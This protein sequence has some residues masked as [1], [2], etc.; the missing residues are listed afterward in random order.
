MKYLRLVHKTWDYFWRVVIIL[1]A[2]T[3]ILCGLLFGV[4]QLKSTKDFLASQAENTYSDQFNGI[5]SIGSF[6]GL[7]PY[8]FNLQDIKVYADSSSAE[9]YIYL[10]SLTF[11]IDPF[12]LLQRE[13]VVNNLNLTNPVI[14]LEYFESLNLENRELN[15]EQGDSTSKKAIEFIV[16]AL[17]I[18]N[19]LIQI[20]SV[21]YADS[22]ISLPDILVLENLDAQLYLDLNSTEQFL[23]IE[24]L[25]F[26]LRNS[27][28]GNI[29]MNGQIFSDA[30]FLEF[31][32]FKLSLEKSF[33]DFSFELGG[34]N[35][36][37][38][39]FYEMIEEAS[40]N[41]DIDASY[42]EMDEIAKVYRVEN[43]P[44]SSIQVEF[45]GLGDIDSL[46]IERLNVVSDD[47]IV[48]VNGYI[49][50]LNSE[51]NLN[52][53][54]NI[55]QA[56]I[57]GNQL[58]FLNLNLTEEQKNSITDIQ[59]S[60]SFGGSLNEIFGNLL[61]RSSRGQLGLTLNTE[62]DND[63]FLN[64]DLEFDSLNISGLFP[65]QLDSTSINGSAS[66]SI[67]SKDLSK[68]SGLAT[69]KFSDVLVDDY[70]IDEI[71][72]ESE[73]KSGYFNPRLIARMGDSGLQLSSEINT[74]TDLN[75]YKL[76]IGIE[77]LNLAEFITVRGLEKTESN[78]TIDVTAY[79]N[80]VSDLY[81]Q[82]SIDADS[83][84][85]NGDTL[86]I[87]QLYFDL[88]SPEEDRV[89]RLTSTPVDITLRGDI[90]PV[91]I[92]QMM[93]HW[94]EYFI[95]RYK[96]ELLF[97]ENI[98]ISEDSLNA[99]QL[100]I[101]YQIQ[102]KDLNLINEYMPAFP[103]I[104]S[105][106]SL[107]GNLNVD[108]KNLLFN[109][110]LVDVFNTFDEVLV[111]SLVT[112]VTGN[113]RYNS[114]LKDFSGLDFNTY[115]KNIEYGE[116]QA[117]GLNFELQLDND[118]LFIFQSVDSLGIEANLY[119]EAQAKLIDS[120]HVLQLNDFQLG[121]DSYKWLNLN[122][123]QISYT[124]N[125][126]LI[127]DELQFINDQQLLRL[128]G[129]ISSDVQDSMFYYIENIELEDLSAIL[130]GRVQFAGLLN[131]NFSTRSL[132][133]SPSIQGDINIDGFEIDE[134]VVGDIDISSVFNEPL[135]RFDT[136]INILTDSLKY[137]DYFIRND[138]SGQNI[139]IAGYI[140]AP[141][142]ITQEIPDSLYNFRL[143]FDDI[144]MWIFPIIAPKVFTEMEGRVTGSGYFKGNINDFDYRI[145][146]SATE[147]I[148]IRP[149]FL[150][151]YY[152]ALG[153]ITF[154]SENGLEFDD[155][156]IIDP[157]GGVGTLNGT[158]NFNNF[159]KNHS[160]DLTLDLDAFHFLN[161]T[162]SIDQPF[163]GDAFGDGRI[164]M[165]G[166][167]FE[168]VI[169]TVGPLILTEG[170]YIGVPLLE[171]TQIEQ[172]RT[173]IRRV[174]S[175]ENLEAQDGNTSS[176]AN[177]GSNLD[178]QELTFIE[179]FTL[180]LQF[181][182]A[183]SMNVDLIFDNVTGDVISTQGTGRLQITLEDQ[184]LSMFGRYDIQSGNYNFVSGDIFTRRFLLNP[185]GSITW[186]GR[187]DDARLNLQAVYRSRPDIRTLSC[188]NQNRLNDPNELPQRRQVDLSLNIGGTISAID[189]SFSF[190]L[191]N[192]I[193]NIQDN[194]LTT[195]LNALN[196]TEDEKLLQ[197]TS[198][199]LTGRFVSICSSQEANSTLTE[200]LSGSSV[201]LN[202][203]LSSQVISPLLSS[204]I[205][206]L[207][208][209][210]VSS[211]DIDFNLNEFNQVDLGVALRLYNDKLIFRR[212][213]QLTGQQSN[214]GDIGA[215]YRINQTISVTAFHRQDPSFGS[216]LSNTT[217][218][219]QDINGLGIKAQIEFD[220]GNELFT[221]IGRFFGRLFGVRRSG[222][223]NSNTEQ[224][225]E[226]RETTND[227]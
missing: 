211:L 162:F 133:R 56:H 95:Q 17:G 175:F 207:L 204:Q 208:R 67:D 226:S 191:P 112:Q 132:T 130:N 165:T 40:L 41:I 88:N 167:S 2:I 215:T 149:R 212:E 225:T 184:D 125:K 25:D 200:G 1:S 44:S 136:S 48:S 135:N 223:N 156:F 64:T 124:E 72:A 77:K 13:V 114:E 37:D 89:L 119:L 118:S 190:L 195:Q 147:S 142:P 28:L 107:I 105:S 39:S 120:A 169:T 59:W 96:S 227:E 173:F 163:Y 92:R 148:Y 170:T 7:L 224:I 47:H 181:E 201:V 121:S 180:D 18:T 61:L 143:K 74:Q 152:Y 76:K 38:D 172:D 84:I 43:L 99:E 71:V 69:L 14:N 68:T 137:P 33:I 102:S 213:G 97:T 106:A 75:S 220:K 53:E 221:K 20:G 57:E 193:D 222:K 54:F 29:N 101:A 35:I 45:H 100:N 86:E 202:P 178:P 104:T 93:N 11:G 145:G 150:D 117:Q 111:D 187:P 49:N 16:P 6:D 91:K 90:N 52:Y 15:D 164:R 80:S 214:I 194:T 78:F 203:L 79:G 166:T 176:A 36:R 153:E 189:N 4:L 139:E 123:P 129:V 65:I 183:N 154:S 134:Q 171:E 177:R 131:G 109:L 116:Y 94:N 216:G 158:Y 21:Q 185:G 141:D 159:S 5:L 160:I 182:T 196:G 205:N 206:S 85:V 199:L 31:N 151:T 174:K 55:E 81:G 161:N 192:T 144:D 58:D 87:H 197:A 50:E 51:E 110:S 122:Q 12:Q 26:D 70:F 115:I 219:V 98:P 60:G 157:T 10:D 128:N 217:Q 82:L 63:S 30:Q 103:E 24:K 19:G 127:F 210:D 126:E 218:Q 66:L 179:R 108:S 186:E 62:F 42:F 8:D 83:S 146:Y 198:L 113:F 27:E 22:N 32:A 138:R 3:I 155:F 23:D 34:L 188:A 209:S 140:N 46:D 73:I 9:P 168:P